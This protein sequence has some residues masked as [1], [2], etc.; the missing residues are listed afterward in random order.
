[1]RAVVLL[2]GGLDSSTCLAL[3]HAKGRELLGLTVCYGQR[4]EAELEAARRVASCFPLIEHRFARVD[5][6]SFGGSALTDDTIAVPKG[7]AADP[8]CIPSTYVPARNTVFLA[9]ALAFAEAREAGEI[10]IGVNALDYSGYPDCRP[11]FLEQF[12]RLAQL[13]T[14]L[15]VE[16]PGSIQVVAPLL[17]LHKHEIIEKGAALGLDYALTL[18]CYD[19]GSDGRACGACEAC[20]LRR[21]GFARAGISDPTRYA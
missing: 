12:Q 16:E 2:S 11:E 21:K 13:A 7:Q 9:M 18:T 4:N 8:S 14:K 17:R 3:A 1:M 5:L 20:G 19:P 15:G 10:W 6:G